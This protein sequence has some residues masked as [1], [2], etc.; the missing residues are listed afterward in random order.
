MVHEYAIA[1]IVTHAMNPFDVLGASFGAVLASHFARA[2]SAVGG[3]SRRAVLLD[4]PPAVPKDL[5][6]PK[7]VKSLRTAAMGILLIQL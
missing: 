7:M 2:A 6:V 3:F 5:P 4:P 1:V